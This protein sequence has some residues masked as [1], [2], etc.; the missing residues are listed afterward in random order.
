VDWA[1]TS[2]VLETERA[3]ARAAEAL[4]AAMDEEEAYASVAGEDANYAG[5]EEGGGYANGQT[6]ARWARHDEA[7]AAFERRAAAAKTK[8]Q[9]RSSS[10]D[11]TDDTR[12]TKAAAVGLHKLNAVD[13]WLESARRVSTLEP[14]K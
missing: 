11:D 4:G 12:R 6:A 2:D 13:P 10:S 7:W 8:Q 9:N 5:D 14:I 1:E 3:A